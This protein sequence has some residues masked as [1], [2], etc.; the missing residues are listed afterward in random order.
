MNV[1]T[2]QTLPLDQLTKEQQK[3][4]EWEELPNDLTEEQMSA[5]KQPMNRHERRAEIARLRKLANNK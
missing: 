4:G 1:N 3:S 2:G 5:L